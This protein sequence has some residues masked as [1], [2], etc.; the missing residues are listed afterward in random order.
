MK[1]LASVIVL[2]ALS[3]ACGNAASPVRENSAAPA[4]ANARQDSV[5]SHG[6]AQTQPAPQAKTRWTQSGDP[7]DVSTQTSAIEK[8][9][10]ALKKDANNEKLKKAL[11]V[12]YYE[13]G[14]VLTEARQYASALGDYRK[15]VKFDPDN[16]DAR[17]W[18]DKIIMIYAGLNKDHP[19][20]GEEPPPLPFKPEKK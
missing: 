13:R 11:S 14:V 12:A 3:M 17:S 5:L 1:V 6:P 20:E 10:A 15:A 8:A 9:E 19:K 7:I 4:D 18:I 16:A 2:S